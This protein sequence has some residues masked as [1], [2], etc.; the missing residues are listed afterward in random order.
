MGQKFIQQTI[1]KYPIPPGPL[2]LHAD[3]GRGMRS[4]LVAFLLPDWGLTKTPSRAYVPDHKPYSESRFCTLESRPQFPDRFGCIQK[5]PAFGQAA[6][7]LAQR[8]SVFDAAHPAHPERFLRSIPKPLPLP[9]QVGIQQP[10]LP[11]PKTN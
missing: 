7:L 1:L 5:A 9:S 10:A 8:Q 4:Q 11:G 3:S 2:S 6:T